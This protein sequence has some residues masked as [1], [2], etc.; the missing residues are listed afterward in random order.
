MCTDTSRNKTDQ[1]QMYELFIQVVQE[2]FFSYI[3]LRLLHG[4]KSRHRAELDS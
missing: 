2:T 1:L 3:L 4:S